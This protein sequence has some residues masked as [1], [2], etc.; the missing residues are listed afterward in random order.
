[1]KI[2]TELIFPGK[3]KDQPVM[4]EVCKKHDILMTIQEATFNA[5]QGWAL[6][7]LNG[8]KADIVKGLAHFKKL[9]V[10]AKKTLNFI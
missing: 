9:G 10:V 2:K 3:L 4:C 6:V 1:M 5:D 8:A 7:T